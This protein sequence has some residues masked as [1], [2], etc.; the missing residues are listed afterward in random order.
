[1]DAGSRHWCTVR[2]G[3]GHKQKHKRFLLNIRKHFFSVRV[4]EQWHGLP[5]ELVKSPSLEIFQ[6]HLEM[7]LGSQL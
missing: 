5:G 6:S 1:M 7:V 2:R 3:N 4:T